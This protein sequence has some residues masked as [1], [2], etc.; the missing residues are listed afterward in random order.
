MSEGGRVEPREPW[1]RVSEEERRGD[2]GV[3]GREWLGIGW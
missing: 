3:R 2:E 1:Y